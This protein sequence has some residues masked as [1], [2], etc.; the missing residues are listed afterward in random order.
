[1]LHLPSG[2]SRACNNLVVIEKATAGQ[3]PW[4]LQTG[5]TMAQTPRTTTVPVQNPTIISKPLV[6]PNIYMKNVATFVAQPNLTSRNAL[7]DM[8]DRFKRLGSRQQQYS[9]VCPASS[10]LTRTFPSRVFRL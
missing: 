5:S 4:N 7:K 3:V 9:P 6:N 8:A 10:R 2:V 1:M